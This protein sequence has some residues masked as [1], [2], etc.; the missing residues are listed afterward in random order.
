MGKGRFWGGQVQIEV[1]EALMQ[2]GESWSAHHREVAIADDGSLDILIQVDSSA[3]VDFTMRATG[4]FQGAFSVVG[5][6]RVSAAVTSIETFN[7]NTFFQAANS[8][9]YSTIFSH[10]A[11]YASGV[12]ARWPVT[13]EAGD[14]QT[15][16]LILSPGL[17][18]LAVQNTSGGAADFIFEAHWEEPDIPV[19][20]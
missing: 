5:S 12:E 15:I 11:S 8:G 10:T 19:T 3:H 4:T 9:G 1:H 6:V 7:R 18:Q 16:S 13:V 14:P 2:Q 20:L 17:Y